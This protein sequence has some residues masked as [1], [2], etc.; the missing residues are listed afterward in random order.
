MCSLFLDSQLPHEAV[1]KRAR[2]MPVVSK[3]LQIEA[4]LNQNVGSPLESLYRI[5]FQWARVHMPEEGAAGLSAAV[6][7]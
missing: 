2:S 3:T 5:P 6:I 1:K 4:V 7:D